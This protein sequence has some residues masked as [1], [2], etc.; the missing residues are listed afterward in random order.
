MNTKATW[1]GVFAVAIFVLHLTL[2]SGDDWTPLWTTATLSQGRC[3]LA[4]TS[5]GGKAFFGGGYIGSGVSDVVDIYDTATG[6]W[7]TKTLSQ[8][9]DWLSA[10]SVG[11]KVVF[12]GGGTTGTASNVVDVFDA[13]SGTSST[14]TLPHAR[15]LLSAASNA[16]NVFFAGGINVNYSNAVDIY[17]TVTGTWSSATLSQ[18][19]RNPAAVA[20]G[21][22]VLFGGGYWYSNGDHCS[23]VVDVYNTITGTW[24]TATLLQGRDVLA[25]ASAG[26]KAFYGGGYNYDT[27]PSNVVDI[28]DAS[29]NTWST[30]TLTQAR[31]WLAAASAMGRVF[32]GGGSGSSGDSNVV[33]IF[34]TVSGTWS[35][36]TLSNAR[37]ELAATSVGNK[38]FFAGGY[39][40]SDGTYSNVVDIY[41]IQNYGTI[42]SSTTFSLVDHTTVAGLMQLNASA[43]LSLG[44]FDLNVGSMSGTAPIDLGHGTLTVGSDNT[45]TTYSGVVSGSGNLTK[46]GIGRLTLPGADSFSGSGAIAV[47]QGGLT[48]PF[49]ISHGG[50]VVTVAGGATLEAGGQIKRAISGTGTV[51]ATADL[52]IGSSTQPGQFNMGGAPGV[53]GTLNAGSNAVVI[54]SSNTAIL[55]SQTNLGDGGSLTTLHGAQLGN[56]SSLDITKV[57]T[58]SG[59]ATVNG[60]FINNGFVQGP[61]GPGQWLTFTQDVEGAGST[62]GDIFYGGS[63]M[64][65]NSPAVVLAEN[66]AFDPT[67]T[68]IMEIGGTAI[69]TQ[70][71]QLDVSGL[72]TLHGTLDVS[73]L[74]GYHLE[75]GHSYQLIDGAT[76]G[77][78]DQVVGLPDGWHVDYSVGGVTVVPEPSTFALLG[79]G[80]IGLLGYVWRRKVNHHAVMLVANALFLMSAGVASADVFNMGGTQNA[81][82]TWNGLASLGFVTVGDAGNAPDPATGNLYGSVGYAYQMGK[83]DVTLGQYCQFLNAVATIS[84]PYGLYDGNLT[85]GF[86]W[87]T[88][89]ITQ[90]G[91]LGSYTYAVTGTVSGGYNINNMPVNAVSWG[92]AARFCNWL[93]N[94]QP[95]AAEGTGTTETGAYTLN[96]VTTYQQ[97]MLVTRNTAVA[98]YFIPTENEWYKAAYYKGGGTAAG[99]WMYPTMSDTAPVNILSTTGT[100]NANYDFVATP[101]NLSPVGYFAGSPGPYGT[102]DQGGDVWQWNETEVDPASRGLRGG[103]FFWGSDT[104]AASYRNLCTPGGENETLGFRVAGVP[105][106]GSIALLLAASLG[107]AGVALHRWRRVNG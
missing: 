16:Q 8:A 69:G 59:S 75:S 33:D 71:D 54:L 29:T 96:G 82:G 68:L 51:S 49:G 86:G 35:T 39:H 94:G 74:D 11:G 93:Q 15:G 47:N 7:S 79:V 38:V 70:Y 27:G 1:K 99:Y 64:P 84:D 30:A 22:K 58:A 43:S 6:A 56:P 73:L 48:I 62:T 46:I 88:F 55:G 28:Y 10:A 67:S 12:G 13:A 104:L 107:V 40:N 26:N 83:Y 90:S 19:R 25:A 42:T 32:F 50:A 45:S 78:F 102:Y 37:N 101:N 44:G 91:T 3:V 60:D 61:T 17:N 53:G 72:A 31:G 89:G 77:Q 57:L 100:N 9:R 24:T 105:E 63:Y 41:T 2:A 4:A 106:P 98:T 87:F 97:L 92:D 81:D 5:A 23:N 52:I 21:D 95:T 65:G 14:A 103:A 66:I 34:D 36:S 20:A 76:T 18:A 80:A 85:N